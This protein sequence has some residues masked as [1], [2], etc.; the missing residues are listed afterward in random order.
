VKADNREYFLQNTIVDSGFV[1]KGGRVRG[2]D[3]KR[4]SSAAFE[5]I[6]II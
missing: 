1:D 4:S 2:G 3:S 5:E 6:N